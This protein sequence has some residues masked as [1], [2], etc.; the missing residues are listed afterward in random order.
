MDRPGPHTTKVE[1]QSL[2][3]VPPELGWVS[4]KFA[5]MIAISGL[6]QKYDTI[7]SEWIYGRS[8]VVRKRPGFVWSINEQCV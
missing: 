3:A 8:T 6:S 1:A 2:T 7:K 5:V 4:N